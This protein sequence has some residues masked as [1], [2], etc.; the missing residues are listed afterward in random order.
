MPYNSRYQ[1]QSTLVTKHYYI[2]EAMKHDWE[3][4]FCYLSRNSYSLFFE[5]KPGPHSKIKLVKKPALLYIKVWQSAYNYSKYPNDPIS[6]DSKYHINDQTRLRCLLY[7]HS[8]CYCVHSSRYS[9]F[10]SFVN[11]ISNST[12]LKYPNLSVA[13]WSKKF[14]RQTPLWK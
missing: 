12:Y 9:Y 1:L 2:D 14:K 5:A 6:L 11:R 3:L 13:Y 10:V 7:F 4:Y 8:F